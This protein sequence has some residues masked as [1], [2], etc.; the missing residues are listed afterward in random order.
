MIQLQKLD[1]LKR[2]ESTRDTKRMRLNTEESEKMPDLQ[3]SLSTSSIENGF[4]AIRSSETGVDS[5]LSLSLTPALSTGNG[6]M[7]K[8]QEKIM[9]S[10]I[11]FF[12]LSSSN[13]STLRMSTL[14]LTM[15]IN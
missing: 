1:V 11:D 12:K 6:K 10:E 13:K 3:L 5:E 9:K 4:D 7:F 2:E 15:S 14:D 8:M